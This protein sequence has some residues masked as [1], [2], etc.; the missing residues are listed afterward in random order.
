MVLRPDGPDPHPYWYAQIIR[1]F[2]VIVNH[3]NLSDSTRMDFLWVR[4]FGSDIDQMYDSGFKARRLHR[5]GFVKD[6]ND[7][8]ASPA[9]GFIDPCNVIRAVYLPPVYEEGKRTDLLSRSM[10]R[11]PSENDE[12]FCLYHVNFFADRD[13]FMRFFGGGIGH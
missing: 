9:F 12:D 5:I 11:L 10:A 6:T 13:L 4:W 2:H 3:P 1:I 7:P 8:E